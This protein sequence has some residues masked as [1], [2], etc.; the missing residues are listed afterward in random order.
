MLHFTRSYSGRSLT[1]IPSSGWTTKSIST[2][3]EQEQQEQPATNSLK[4]MPRWKRTRLRKSIA[5][6]ESTHSRAGPADLAVSEAPP[7]ALGIVNPGFSYSGGLTVLDAPDARP[8]KD[9]PEVEGR[10][11]QLFSTGDLPEPRRYASSVVPM[12]GCSS[13]DNLL[14]REHHRLEED[15]MLKYRQ[16]SGDLRSSC[17]LVELARKQEAEVRDKSFI[18][19][20]AV[21][22]E[23]RKKRWRNVSAD[24]L[25]DVRRPPGG[26]HDRVGMVDDGDL[27]GDTGRHCYVNPGLDSSSP[28]IPC[29]K[30]NPRA[31][32]LA[33]Q[34]ICDLSPVP[35]PE[36]VVFNLNRHSKYNTS[37]RLATN[38]PATPVQRMPRTSTQVC[39]DLATVNSSQP[40]TKHHLLLRRRPPQVEVSTAAA[41]ADDCLYVRA[42]PYL[43]NN[44]E[45]SSV[46]AAPVE[47]LYTRTGGAGGPLQRYTV[48]GILGGGQPLPLEQGNPL[49][50]RHS[51]ARLS[52]SSQ[53]T[54][55][56]GRYSD[57]RQVLSIRVEQNS[58]MSV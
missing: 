51:V 48:S 12:R 15:F 13:V 57:L 32:P 58:K 56:S 21:R 55:D 11:R 53:A 27:Y 39:L 33:H 36:D 2:Q 50:V 35:R 54:V 46:A 10:S 8:T 52:R 34:E 22:K 47:A 3:T 42:E 17:D 16:V 24:R 25:A 6:M 41:A 20:K 23:K 1:H 45:A 30:E 31:A 43:C 19:S 38:Q 28:L 26:G 40:T 14:D 29:G 18:E 5:V 37:Y 9:V 44:S 49:L 7:P 4:R